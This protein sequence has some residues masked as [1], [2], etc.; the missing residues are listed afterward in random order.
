[1][2][3]VSC[4]LPIRENAQRRQYILINSAVRYPCCA[5]VANQSDPVAVIKPYIR[6]QIWKQIRANHRVNWT[7][8]GLA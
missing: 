1:M 6:N 2:V 5:W 3:R 8:I 4:Y 7:K